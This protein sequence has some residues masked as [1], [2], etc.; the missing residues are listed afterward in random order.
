MAKYGLWQSVKHYMLSDLRPVLESDSVTD[1][2]NFALERGWYAPAPAVIA[3]NDMGTWIPS[4]WV[5]KSGLVDLK[6]DQPIKYVEV[7][8]GKR[9]WPN[10]L[11]EPPSV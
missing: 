1:L 7:R 2:E 6:P 9:P 11:G 3:R 5:R 4:I 8:E 10:H